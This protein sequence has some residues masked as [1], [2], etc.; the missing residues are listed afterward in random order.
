[1]L[2][3][4][5]SAKQILELTREAQLVE[6]LTAHL[7]RVGF[8]ISKSERSSWQQSLPALAMEL[9]G[10]GLGELDVLVEC[11]LPR[12]SKRI[13]VI[14]AGMEP[15]TRRPAYLVVELKQWS[16]ATTYDEAEKLVQ[17]PGMAEPQVHP[18]VQVENYCSYL[19]DF[20]PMF[21]ESPDRVHGLAYLHNAEQGHI[22]AMTT[23]EDDGRSHRR[24]VFTRDRTREM[25]RYLS[26]RFAPWRD[27]A[28]TQTL[29]TAA[30]KPSRQLLTF[31]AEE[32]NSRGHLVLLDEQRAA[33]ELVMRGVHWADQGRRKRVVL[34]TGGPGSGKSAIA[35]TLLTDLAREGRS[36]AHATGSKAFRE[37]LRRYARSQPRSPDQRI[38]PL[39]HYFMDFMDEP[40]D[41]L[42]VL[43]CDEAHR[44]RAQSSRGSRRGRKPQ[45]RELI[46]VA[47]VPVFLL[48]DDQVVRPNEVGS[49]SMIRDAAERLDLE[50]DFVH[51]GAQFRC[52]GSPRYERWVHHLLGLAADRPYRWSGDESFRLA[53]ADSPGQME[54]LLRRTHNRKASARISAGFCWPWTEKPRGRDLVPDIR[55]GPWSK[56][57]NAAGM[58]PPRG[59]PSSSFWAVDP[60]GFEQVGCIYTAQG[61][62][63]DWSGVILGPDLVF[64]NGRLISQPSKSHDSA[65]FDQRR[66]VVARDADRLIRNTYKVLLTRGMRGTLIYSADP[67]TQQFLASLV[68]PAQVPRSLVA[69][70]VQRVGVPADQTSSVPDRSSGQNLR[71]SSTGA[72]GSHGAG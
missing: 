61:F 22:P 19:T 43:I 63:Y 26:R 31:S 28:A 54:T 23:K 14:L 59:I 52:G 38:A 10:A 62:E 66:G 64:R 6:Q 35:L 8:R 72:S 12:S 49:V 65:I 45:V 36:V 50:V 33:Y 15:L 25:R 9:V 32:L 46:E 60:D 18:A 11:Q 4:Q 51:L 48:D 16:V 53:L 67:E 39:F 55:I 24:M 47:K 68:P 13:D 40:A 69:D 3:F 41:S 37:S 29:L 34:V 42:D 1:M 44:I 27:E 30:V 17:V 20:L 56:P 58:R 71:T 2:A 5:T 21:A 7:T 70:G 57:W